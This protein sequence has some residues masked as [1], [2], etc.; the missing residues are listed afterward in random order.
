MKERFPDNNQRLAV[1]FK[2]FGDSIDY[3]PEPN[4]FITV[5]SEG[6]F[7]GY[8]S[9]FNVPDMQGDIVAPG[10][11]TAALAEKGARGVR[12]LFE[13]DNTVP[14]GHWIDMRQDQY[15][16]FV[17]GQLDLNVERAREIKSL[18]ESGAV[19]GL[20]IAGIVQASEKNQY[21][22]DVLKSIDLWEI[23]IC[24]FPVQ[25]QAGVDTND[26]LLRAYGHRSRLPVVV[27]RILP[28]DAQE[29]YR[30]AYNRFVRVHPDGSYARAHAIAWRAVRKNWNPPHETV[31]KWSRR[32]GDCTM[33]FTDTVVFDGS[34]RTEDGF[35]AGNVRVARTGIQ[36]YRGW[37]VGRP[38]MQEVRVYR[39]EREVFHKDAMH[40]FSHR[41]VTL[42][43]PD[44]MVTAK[45]WKQYAIG[46]TGDEVLRDGE[47][48]RVPMVLMDAAA[49]SA[50]EGGKRQL[51]MGYTCDLKWQDG[52]TPQGEKYDAVQTAIRGN[53]LAVVGAARG[54]AQ[55]RIDGD[56]VTFIEDAVTLNGAGNSYAKSLVSSGKVNETDGWSFSAEDGDALLGKSGD[57]WANYG[58]HHLGIDGSAAEDTK[59][60]YKYPFAKG[61]TLYRSALRAI[62]SRASQNGADAVFEAA[63]KLIDSLDSKS[64]AHDETPSQRKEM[65]MS[66]VKFEKVTLGGVETE[67]TDTLAAIIRKEQ[68]E[69]VATVAALTEKAQQAEAAMTAKDAEIAALAQQV[70]DAELTPAKLDEAVKARAALIA[71]AKSINDADY[72]G[73][74]D[75]EI[76]R[77]VVDAKLGEK[78]KD[79]SDAQVA[80]G[81]ETM[82]AFASAKPSDEDKLAG[83]IKDKKPAPTGRAV[84][85]EAWA[86][87]NASMKDAWKTPTK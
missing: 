64:K 33:K 82:A 28:A 22:H 19:D 48:L 5:T 1:C 57:D 55:L 35:L 79:W 9:L 8:A 81:F 32:I 42:D 23:S 44:E 51:S 24:S 74:T 14:L 21:G 26:S 43:H 78:A 4:N 2:Q 54:G 30:R 16:L 70:K 7:S 72:E 41:P 38:D 86:K 11:F 17:R 3:M 29:V 66:D 45:N 31:G 62:R 40:S 69:H 67:V 73:K 36:V 53:H 75:G 71:T 49:I 13:H 61:G 83:A 84:A 27:R 12:M 58:K 25:K 65:K 20:S 63:G 37:E 6:V 68:A 85:D 46:Q 87:R 56:P 18:M 80:T 47:F 39:P 50:V 52:V 60:H 10:A 76:R 34:R 59:E 77:M 15:G